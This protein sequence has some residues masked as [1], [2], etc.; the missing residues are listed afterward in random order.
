MIF[1]SCGFLC[2]WTMLVVGFTSIFVNRNVRRGLQNY[3]FMPIYS[4][5]L[6]ADCLCYD[7][8]DKWLEFDEF[9]FELS[10]KDE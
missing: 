3:F 5:T 2:I 6:L 10:I 7:Q 4:A 8:S 9:S 1:I